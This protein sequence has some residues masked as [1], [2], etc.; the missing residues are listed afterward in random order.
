MD[1]NA[2]IKQKAKIKLTDKY[3]DLLTSDHVYG[4]IPYEDISSNVINAFVAL[5]DKRFFTH[6]GIDYYRTAGALIHNIR[7]GKIKE[8]GSTI[9]QQ[10]AKNTMLSSEKTLSRKIKEMA[11]AGKIEKKFT[12]EE[13]LEMNLNAIYYGNGIYGIDS[14][15]H[16]YFGKEPSELTP[17]EGA[18]LAGIVKN[19]SK[20]SP[21][22]DSKA[23]SERKNL[24]LKLMKEQNFIT[25]TEYEDGLAYAYTEP[26]RK[27][28]PARSYFVSAIHE[29]ADILG[30]SEE[31]VI[32]SD[33]VIHTF[34]DP[35]AQT[36]VFSSFESGEYTDYNKDGVAAD[37]TALLT[38]NKTGGI[39]AYYSTTNDNVFTF[40]RSPASA[41]KPILVYA[42]AIEQGIITEKSVFNDEKSVFNGYSPK[43]YGDV[44]YGMITADK[45]LAKSVNTVAVR[46]LEQTGVENS[47]QFAE[48]AGL[49]FNDSDKNHLAIA[50]GGMTYGVTLPELTESYMTLASMG[51]HKNATFIR[52]VSTGDGSAIYTQIDKQTRAFSAA[53]A[54]I[55]TDMLKKTVT[56]GT[57]RKLL[58]FPFEIAAKTGTAESS[59][60]NGN[61]DAWN[62][63]YT[64]ADTLCIWYGAARGSAMD[65]TG[66]NYP[67]LLAA[68]I[69]RKIKAPE[70]NLFDEPMTVAE[71]EIDAYALN[72]DGKLY[73]STRYTPSVYREKG[74]FA[75]ENAPSEPS[76]YFDLTEIEFDFS[77]E[78]D[79]TLFSVSSPSPFR[80]K[81]I[82]RNL[83]T[84]EVKEY[85]GVPEFLP[86]DKEKNTIYS[87]Y[88]G[89][90]CENEFLGYTPNK[91]QFT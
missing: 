51:K 34:Y 24:V 80:Y 53:T 12:K 54:Y 56:D 73:L 90:Y 11:L 68:D 14:A 35:A 82:E 60:G 9:T 39:I 13:I 29:A 45:A 26:A 58:G 64:T 7:S 89:V 66:G 59:T 38:D 79:K 4:Y 5:E 17:A 86:N 19:P 55:V 40:R 27:P 1:E 28:D 83:R 71:Y 49:K 78:G 61:S 16:N 8:G 87:Y 47:V 37:Y 42:P 63:S 62:I 21:A 57:A 32:R 46:I 74:H 84:R 88:L 81:L 50:L 6:K 91:L 67:T 2:I 48:K 75:I 23:V 3:G 31:E 76:P 43:N 25:E 22:K 33:Y 70:K 18:F 36:A 65:T 72:N 52:S 69:R 15:C 77:V 44:Y 30:I 85:D 41:I 20:Y 10:L